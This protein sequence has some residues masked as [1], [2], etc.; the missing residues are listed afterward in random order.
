MCIRKRVHG[1]QGW[2]KTNSGAGNGVNVNHREEDK[3]EVSGIALP[4]ILS[5]ADGWEVDVI[6]GTYQ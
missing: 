3:Q 2:G 6:D 5:S 4:M 1:S